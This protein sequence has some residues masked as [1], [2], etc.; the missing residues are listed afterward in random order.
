MA[1]L[2]PITNAP[3]SQKILL[4][5]M[6]LAIIGAGGYFLLLS[7][8]MAEVGGLRSR[9][10]TLQSELIQSRALAQNLARFRQEAARLRERL[11]AARERLPSEKEMPGLYRRI[12]ELAFQAGLAVSLFQ[13]KDP[14]PKAFY[15]EVPIVVSLESNFHQLGSFFDR[16]SRLPRIVT[17]TAMKLTGIERGGSSQGGPPTVKADFTLTTYL[18]RPHGAPPPALPAGAKR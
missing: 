10:T 6:L 8:K 15:S 17:L 18:F 12:S 11:E 13:P 1:L 2:D 16:L 7:P 9:H 3:R 5:V 4:G 14:Q